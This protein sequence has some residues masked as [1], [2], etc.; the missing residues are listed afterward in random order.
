MRRDAWRTIDRRKNLRHRVQLPVLFQW[1]DGIPHTEG[2][3]TRDVSLRAFFVSSTA[4]PPVKALIK[5]QILIPASGNN[6]GNA[7]KA[8]GRV[9][10]LSSQGEERG[11]ALRAQHYTSKKFAKPHLQ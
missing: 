6:P 3:F 5:C 4:M 11:F 1:V 8:A 2:G 7:I 9:V 10:R